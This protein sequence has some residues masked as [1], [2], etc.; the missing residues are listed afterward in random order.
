MTRNIT[1]K[2]TNTENI[3]LINYKLDEIQND[4]AKINKKL[5]E[6]VATKEWVNS[7]YG[8]TKRMVNALLITFGTA[9]VLAFASFMIGGG[10]K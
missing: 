4:I 8:Q 3:D 2:N 5:D 1:N 10:L 9:I 7:E 6:N